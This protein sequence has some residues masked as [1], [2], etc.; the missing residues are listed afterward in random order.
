MCPLFSNKVIFYG[1]SAKDCNASATKNKI[2]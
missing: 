1:I 2:A